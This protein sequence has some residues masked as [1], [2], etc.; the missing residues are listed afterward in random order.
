[1]IGTAEPNSTV[2]LTINGNTTLTVTAAADGTWSYQPTPALANNTSVTITATDR[3]GNISQQ[4]S[5][6]IDAQAPDRPTISN[7][8]GTVFSG[9]AEAGSTII[10]SDS[11][12]VIGQALVDANGNW[13]FTASPAITNGSQVSVVARDAAGNVGQ[14]E[15]VVV[16]N[17]LPNAPIIA[18]S[19]GTLIAGTADAGSLVIVI[20]NGSEIGR[21]IAGANGTW[22]ITPPSALA[23]GTVISA[24]ASTPAGTSAGTTLIIDA[25]Q[26]LPPVVQP[27]NG[28]E[29]S[30]T[31]EPG[32]KIILIYNNGELIGQT[33][34]D[35]NG[36]WNFIPTTPLADGA[37]IEIRVRDA[38]LLYT[39]PSP[40]D[41]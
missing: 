17:A 34:A 10:L 30:G 32:G 18:A 3:A 8:N 35:A 36:N 13:H 12:G 38:C 9:S 25:V 7:S 20:A 1:M 26:P 11:N 14:A 41:S 15:A 21:V 27:S 28:S 37:A 33:V 31:A 39:S 4:T 23:D 24:T 19:N 29:L 2:T 22:T 16:N 6:T 40:R 5:L